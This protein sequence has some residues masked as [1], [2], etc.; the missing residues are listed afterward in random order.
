MFLALL[1]PPEVEEKVACLVARR[2]FL[3][4]GHEPA[5]PHRRGHAVCCQLGLEDLQEK[6]EFREEDMLGNETR[7]DWCCYRLCFRSNV[8]A[9][10]GSVMSFEE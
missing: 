2:G 7:L 10:F 1:R 4:S 9:I 8:A 5:L 3:Q 6:K